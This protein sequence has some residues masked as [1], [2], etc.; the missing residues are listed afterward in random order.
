MS[1]VVNAADISFNEGLIRLAAIHDKDV[2]FRYAKGDGST[3]ETRTFRPEK[4][5]QF[6]GH[7]TFLGYDPDRDET[8]SYR[9]DRIK[10]E[11]TVA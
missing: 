4:V 11:V 7:V 5:A 1:N 8:R 3:I 2:T 6:P 10:G 9:S